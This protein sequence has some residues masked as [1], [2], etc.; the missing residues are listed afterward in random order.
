MLGFK[1]TASLP[2]EGIW[3][4]EGNQLLERRDDSKANKVALR[5]NF[6][7]LQLSES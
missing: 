2:P 7:K 5:V 3:W 4:E 1:E 6:A